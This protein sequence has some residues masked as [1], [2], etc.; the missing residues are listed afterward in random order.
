[1]INESL[2]RTLWPGQNAVGQMLAQDGGRQ[3]VGV[4][5]DVR[6]GAI[7]DVGGGEMYL[8]IRQTFDYAAV[9]LVV[10][11]SLP[12]G[13]AANA[14]RAALRPV[15]PNMPLRDFRALQELVDQ[16][17]SPRRFLVWLLG[18][19]AGFALL[20]ASLGI[21]ALIA[22]SVSQRIQEIGIRM[23]LGASAA[24][25]QGGILRQTL[26]LA[27]IGLALGLVTS[28]LL[29]SAIGSMLFGVTAGDPAT[30]VGMGVLLIAVA[31]VAGYVPCQTGVAGGSDGGPASKLK[32]IM[33][34]CRRPVTERWSPDFSDTSLS[35]PIWTYLSDERAILCNSLEWTDWSANPV[36][37]EVCDQCGTSA[38]ASGGYVHISTFE[39]LCILDKTSSTGGWKRDG[40]REV[41]FSCFS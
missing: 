36:Q 22:Y 13:A 12:A 1:M 32:A 31:V 26:L 8:P 29:A 33:L 41:R 20:L 24:N 23:A 25:L 10:R 38:C 5:G 39:R 40:Y 19:F 15:D 30:F 37:V 3:V 2:A 16:A 34:Y 35:N 27:A 4:V 14:V 11:T 21:Y 28:R 7:E 18:G 17:S 6:H 9:D